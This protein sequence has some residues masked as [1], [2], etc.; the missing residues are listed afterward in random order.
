MRFMRAFQRFGGIR[1]SAA[2]LLIA[3]GLW[4]CKKTDAITNPKQVVPPPS[5]LLAAPYELTA[6]AVSVSEI[7]LTWKDSMSDNSAFVLET[8]VDTSNTYSVVDTIGRLYRIYHHVLLRCGTRYTYRLWAIN[9]AKK[10]PSS[11][12]ARATTDISI[13]GSASLSSLADY[14]AVRFV[15][16]SI[17][18]AAGS[19][20]HLLRTLNGGATWD[21]LASHTLSTLNGLAFLTPS[22]GKTVG[23][24]GTIIGTTDGG[25]TWT[26][27]TSGISSELDAVAA[28]DS[29]H[30]VAVGASSMILTTSNGGSAWVV[31]SSPTS[32]SFSSVAFPL[33]SLGYIVGSSSSMLVSVDTGKT[34]ANK[35]VNVT[36]DLTSMAFLDS[37]NGFA[38]G[39]P[40][41]IL[42]T[43]DGGYNWNVINSLAVP[44]TGVAIA[45]KNSAVAVGSGG[46]VYQ[47]ADGGATWMRSTLSGGPWLQSVAF[48]PPYE[49]F[50][51]GTHGSAGTMT[52]C[53]H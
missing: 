28:I 12:Y 42:Q 1:L 36:T 4:S 52:V 31:R 49:Y 5:S 47:T 43:T 21:S 53:E 20:G 48:V 35:T 19:K 27:D 9:G 33:P 32:I 7:D 23:A 26:A 8:A 51:V 40:G 37:L 3:A 50:T 18:F 34:W 15:T 17:G 45:S 6:S 38:V 24:G 25:T 46:A 16:P 13:L 11:N 30:W 14:Y 29:A 44:F 22:I 10:S 2:L 41:A 39:S